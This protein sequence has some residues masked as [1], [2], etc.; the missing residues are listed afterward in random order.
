M[1]N[2]SATQ[3]P[4]HGSPRDRGSADAYYGKPAKP[5]WYP[6]GTYK[7]VRVCSKDMTDE[8]VGEYYFGYSHEE[9]RK[10]WNQW[11]QGA[12]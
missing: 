11:H 6:L 5:H 12:T 8:E 2:E 7:G 10:D 9:D 4:K 3:L 1:E